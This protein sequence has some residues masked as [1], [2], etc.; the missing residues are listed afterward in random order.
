MES[1][2]PII[3]RDAQSHCII[4]RSASNMMS[5]NF[6][7]SKTLVDRREEYRQG[8]RIVLG[9]SRMKGETAMDPQRPCTILRVP[10]SFYEDR[11]CRRR[12]VLWPAPQPPCCY[13]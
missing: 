2:R 13:C 9:G 10:G 3:T 7:V 5:Q 1:M 12:V 8:T 11:V 4:K 6:M